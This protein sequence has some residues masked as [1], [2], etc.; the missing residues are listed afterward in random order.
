MWA[1]GASHGTALGV[2]LHAARPNALQRGRAEPPCG[3]A[4]DDDD[5][6]QDDDEGQHGLCREEHE[7]RAKKYGDSEMRIAMVTRCG[8]DLIG[9]T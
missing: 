7:E 6:I 5:E 4:P 3:R 1:P 2:V 9:R 8:A